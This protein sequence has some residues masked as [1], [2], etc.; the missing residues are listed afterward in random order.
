[1]VVLAPLLVLLALKLARWTG[2]SVLAFYGIGVITS[3]V[4]VIYLAMS[5]YE[6]PAEAG[7]GA[8][9]SSEWP[10]VSCL[11]AVY[12]E[13]DQIERCVRSLLDSDYPALEVI[14]VDDAS[15]D[16]TAALL[17]RMAADGSFRLLALA[18]NV[19]K[20][21]ALTAGARISRGKYFVFSDSDCVV[22]PDAI[23]R[24]IGAMERNSS[25]GAV[26]GHA[27]AL[28][29]DT[30]PL[31]KAQ[32]VWYDGQFSI[33]KGAES[34]F[35]SV[36]CVSGP[37]AVFRRESIVNYLPAWANDRF[38]GKEFRF[39]TDR[40]LTGY[41]LV[42][43]RMGRRLRDRYKNDPLVADEEFRPGRWQVG[44]VRSAQVWTTV[45]VTLKSFLRQQTRW[46]KSFIR[47]LFFTGRFY[48]RRG[49]V[50]A[51][52]YY[53]HVA[54]V[55]LAPVMAFRH[56]VWLPMHGVWFLSLLY[57]TG[58]S[59]KGFVWGAVFKVQHPRE[60]SWIYRPLMSLLSAVVLSWLLLYA[61]LTLR[62][63]NWFRGAR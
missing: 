28:N 26:S 37:L 48:W 6:D 49:P 20:K 42:G 33:I 46:K 40:Q 43:D 56:L 51:T 30:N 39:A 38:V 5:Y 52:M 4:F 25:L 3:T 17:E 11:V 63:A 50:P 58:V 54:W 31:T 21:R 61:M 44:Y 55:L 24:C 47:S 19:G 8:M 29:A 32:D 36:T 62:R 9:I 13:A 45:P 53:G 14:I 41:V 60:S 35:G 27:R 10:L 18:Q 34:V 7:G 22:A 12:N 15:N 1:M 2:D 57:L 16:G 59:V 23:R